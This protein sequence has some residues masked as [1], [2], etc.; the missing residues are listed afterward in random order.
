[1]RET[2]KQVRNKSKKNSG[3]RDREECEERGVIEKEE[4]ER[5]RSETNRGAGEQRNKRDREAIT[6]E[7]R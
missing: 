5:Q 7:K 4:G 1:M 3:A 6:M 2:E